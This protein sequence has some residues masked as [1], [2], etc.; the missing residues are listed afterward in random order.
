MPRQLLAGRDSEQIV[1]DLI[2][3]DYSPAAARALIAR[4]ENDLRRLYASPE[5]R[6]R[7]MKEARQQCVGG[8]ILALLGALITAYTFIASL[9]GYVPFVVVA[10]GFVCGGI[11][12]AKR[13]YT[14]WSLCR[15]AS[16]RY[17]HPVQSNKNS[18]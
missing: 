1:A 2:K 15:Q 3:L 9:A 16:Q 7:L 18:T 8:A 14:R 12:L 5:S 4:V 11:M 17:D 13:G 10:I 6:Q